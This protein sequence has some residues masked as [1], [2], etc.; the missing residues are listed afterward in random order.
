MEWI[1]CEDRLPEQIGSYLAYYSTK[2]Q[3][4][5]WLNS[6]GWVFFNSDKNFAIPSGGFAEKVTHWMPLPEPPKEQEE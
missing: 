3:D 1:K 2:G 6:I 5:M 4:N